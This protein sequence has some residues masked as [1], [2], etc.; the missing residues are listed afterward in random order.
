MA[1]TIPNRFINA[2]TI[3]AAKFNSNFDTISSWGTTQEA[4]IATL[5]ATSA[6]HTSQ[7]TALGTPAAVQSFFA[8]LAAPQTIANATTYTTIMVD[9]TG[10]NAFDQST[11]FDV[12]TATY[13]PTVAGAY[14]FDVN[15]Q[16]AESGFDSNETVS[17]YIVK[18]A[19]T[20]FE[21]LTLHD[22]Y[23]H[24]GGASLILKANG[25]TDYFHIQ[26]YVSAGTNTAISRAYFC[27]AL[28]AA[29]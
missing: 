23:A 1:L 2:Q 25:T 21:V 3:D 20:R 11:K 14:R 13:T 12:T 29:D 22:S 4:S 27:G 17:V 9:D 5:E 16:L 6:T 28:V 18:N 19:A 26:A 7:I 24:G 8:Y 15:I 10:V